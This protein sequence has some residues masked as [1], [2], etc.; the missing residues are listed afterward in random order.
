MYYSTRNRSLNISLEEAVMQGMP[1]DGGLFMPRCVKEL[2]P[3]FFNELKDMT[4]QE[5]AFRVS[6]NLF[7]ELEREMIREIVS[8][9]FDFDVVLK[10][11][12]GNMHVL[13][14][15]HGPTLAFKDFGARFMARLM[16]Q[17]VKGSTSHLNILVAT[18]GDTGSAVANGFYDV[19]GIRVIILYPK[20]KIS[21]VQEKQI[22]T[23]DRNILS[24]EVDGV[25]DDCQRLVKEV[26][27]DRELTERF[28]F[29]SANSIN[30]ARLLPQCFYYFSAVSQL[31]RES[32]SKGRIV[33]SVPSGNFGNL[34]AGLIAWK[35]GLPIDKFIAATNV[36]RVVPEYLSTGHFNPKA[37]IRTISNAMDVGDPSNF[38]RMLELF[39]NDW[40]KAGSLVEGFWYSDEDTLET[41]GQ[42]HKETG[43]VLDPHGAVGY[44]G[45][46]DFLEANHGYTGIFLE[47]ASPA[48][49][50]DVVEPVINERIDL[51]ERLSRYLNQ[52]KRSIPMA[53]DFSSFRKFL[54]EN[55][56]QTHIS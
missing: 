34:T 35:Q 22:S 19:P 32:S 26:F 29:S 38:V 46:K 54:I 7:P 43:Y 49:F 24:L 37:S 23:L 36:N 31:M 48:K 13:E 33:F 51:P 2:P 6:E 42:V 12:A 21:M 56:D 16:S 47:T 45:L 52:P 44:R 20:G 41:I 9:A 1:Q 50:A 11:L 53:R 8:Q 27:G 18:S 15:F 30:I 14:L 10:P 28:N 40:K 5:I 25:F 4:F 55:L 17:F 39:D 3:S